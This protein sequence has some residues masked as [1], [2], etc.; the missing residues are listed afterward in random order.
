MPETEPRT[1]DPQGQDL[2]RV[3]A[4]AIPADEPAEHPTT[5]LPQAR[6]ADEH[7]GAEAG[8]P[9]VGSAS[10]SQDDGDRARH[11][12]RSDRDRADRD[13]PAGPAHADPSSRRARKAKARE[14]HS[15]LFLWLKVRPFGDIG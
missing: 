4:S 10:A 13:R 1:P 7:A 8:A 14:G 6:V 12:E 9:A 5:R 2:P 15:P 11:A 3:T